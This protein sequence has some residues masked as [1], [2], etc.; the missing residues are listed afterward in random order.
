MDHPE[1][2]DPQLW[3]AGTSVTR[4]DEDLISPAH[5][6]TT[7]SVAGYAAYFTGHTLHPTRIAEQP[8][9]N[10][11]DEVD[12]VARRELGLSEAEAEWLFEPTR[13]RA[14]VL[15]ALGQLAS[16]ATHITTVR[17]ADYQAAASTV[18]AALTLARGTSLDAAV[19]ALELI[20][21]DGDFDDARDSDPAWPTGE[22]VGAV[23]ALRDLRDIRSRPDATE[24]VKRT[25]HAKALTALRSFRSLL[26][27]LAAAGA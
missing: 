23:F 18:D 14:E 24:E 6:G 16:G 13:T 10:R 1:R 2:R 3:L 11:H 4:P 22:N 20:D 12:E 9:T 25:A 19:R 17:I 21:E 15:T 7:P 5:C 27:R 8:G 26:R